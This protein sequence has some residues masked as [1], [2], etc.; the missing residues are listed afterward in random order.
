MKLKFIGNKIRPLDAQI[1]KSEPS[2]V[3]K[4][5]FT[6]QLVGSKGSSKT[7]TI[8]NM[9]LNKNIL[10]GKFERIFF[11]SPTSHLDEKLNV[12]KEHNVKCFN[13]PLINELKKN[14]KNTLKIT[15]DPTNLP[16]NNLKLSD[17]DF[18]EDVSTS[19]LQELIKEQKYIIEKYGKKLADNILLIYDD[20]AS[21]KKFFNSEITKK[22]IYNSRHV[23]ISII[24]SVQNYTSISKP[25][26][27]NNSI[28]LLYTTSNEK[29]L[30]N[31][32][33][34]N[35]C[36]HNFKEFCEKF[37]KVTDIPFSFLTINYQNDLTH[38][39]ENNFENFI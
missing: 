39:Y 20:C 23:K 7:S 36:S 37:H 27:L 4:L 9:L 5:P 2:L 26:R 21:E 3:P 25:I 12:L 17:Q 11:I 34:E 14:R 29:E 35:S 1:N 15:D 16:E 32:Y 31:I 30:K 10:N 18:I 13:Y 6:C 33:E 22:L 19:F 24:F 28:L 8:L 38:R